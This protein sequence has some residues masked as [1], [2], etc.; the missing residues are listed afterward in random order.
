[1]VDPYSA[2]LFDKNPFAKR[3]EIRGQLVVVLDGRL[4]GRNLQLIVPL[5]RALLQGD[6]HELISTDQVAGPGQE[7]ARVSYLGFFE[8]SQGGV[9]VVGDKLAVAG[10]M[11]GTVAGFDI[12]HLPNH[13]NIVINRDDRATGLELGLGLGDELRFVPPPRRSEAPIDGKLDSEPNQC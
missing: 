1:M 13:L 5:S 2:R 7:V 10:Q 4:E 8:V 12:T 11:L 3:R 9:V 6:I